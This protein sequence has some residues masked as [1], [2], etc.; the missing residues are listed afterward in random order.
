VVWVNSRSLE[1]SNLILKIMILIILY[2]Y[3]IYRMALGAEN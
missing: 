2:F 1:S 3:S